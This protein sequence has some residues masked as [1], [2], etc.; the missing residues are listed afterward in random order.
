MFNNLCCANSLTVYQF[1]ESAFH[2]FQVEGTE[3]KTAPESIQ[4]IHDT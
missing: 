2:R 1:H 4:S 3:L